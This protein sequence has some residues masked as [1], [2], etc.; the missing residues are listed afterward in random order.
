[1]SVAALALVCTLAAADVEELEAERTRVAHRLEAQESALALL[2]DE[3]VSVL[4]VLELYQLLA[5]RAR[6]RARWTQGELDHLSARVREAERE[7][8][9]ANAA[10]KEE[11]AVLAPRLVQLYRLTR[12]SPL[13]LLLPSQSLAA[14]VRRS[15]ALYAL[16]GQDILTLRRVHRLSQ[17]EA[18]SLG[19]LDALKANLGEQLDGLTAELDEAREQRAELADLLTLLAARA[20]ESGRAAKELKSAGDRL[21]RM[22]AELSQTPE[23]QGFGALK[24]KLPFP[25]ERGRVEVA[26]GNVVNPR[27]NTVT[28]QKGLDIR[29]PLGAEVRAVA[30]GKVVYASTMRGYGNLLIVDHGGGYHTLMAHLAEL[31]R[32][33]G[34]VVGAGE[35]LGRVGD[36][37][38]LK[39]AYLYFELRQRGL[40]IDPSAWLSQV[41]K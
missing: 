38:S 36:T 39:G 11:R 28:A 33:V 12:R 27:F 6:A 29:A 15:R 16:M 21:D 20:R 30:P 8:A 23:E 25:V 4:E 40:T 14:L 34:D 35:V 26:F 41:T 37:G 19:R 5:E 31:E 18:E 2:K 24:G 22:I 9:L 10:L 17:F 7:E 13:D 32:A 3:R 1:M